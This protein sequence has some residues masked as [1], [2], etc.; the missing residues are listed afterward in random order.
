MLKV[1]VF[2]NQ[3]VVLSQF[4]YIGEIKI[5]SIDYEVIAY[6]LLYLNENF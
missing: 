6:I 4:K 3:I 5:L 2:C 1:Y